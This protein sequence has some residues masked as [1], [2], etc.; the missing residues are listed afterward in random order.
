M[1]KRSLIVGVLSVAMIGS[2]MSA[3]ADHDWGNY[4]GHDRGQHVYQNYEVRHYDHDYGRRDG[5]WNRG[6]ASYLQWNNA[7]R[8]SPRYVETRSH[9]YAPVAYGWHRGD[10]LPPTYWHDRY[11]V[12]DWHSYPGLYEPPHGYRWLN[13]DGGFVLAAIATGVIA[14]IL[15]NR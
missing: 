15:L 4:R 1:M 13:V 12:N 6:Y 10:R 3:M 5:G 14:T 9:G 7:P 2:S 8:W 11:Y